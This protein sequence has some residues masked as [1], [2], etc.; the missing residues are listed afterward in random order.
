MNAPQLEDSKMS[1]RNSK[2]TSK[3]TAN[4]GKATGSEKQADATKPVKD[5]SKHGLNGFDARLIVRSITAAFE[6]S[7]QAKA[8]A[9]L[10]SVAALAICKYAHKLRT[11]KANASLTGES[12]AAGW[13]YDMKGLLPELHTAGIDWVKVRAGADDRQLYALTSYGQNVSSFANQCGQYADIKDDEDN[14]IINFNEIDSYTQVMNAVKS[15]KRID[16]QRSMNDAE[17]ELET[18]LALFTE[19]SEAF[20]KIVRHSELLGVVERATEVM[21][22]LIRREA[23]ETEAIANPGKDGVIA[24]IEPDEVLTVLQDAI[25]GEDSQPD[26]ETAGGQIGRTIVENAEAAAAAG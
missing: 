3:K 7:K 15:A 12:F 4:S 25:D 18:A 24:E 8:F 1:K 2:K 6:A 20:S 19:S 14:L 21:V 10:K 11:S 26:A 9:D 16:A 23:L 5:A 13:R 17:R 22:A